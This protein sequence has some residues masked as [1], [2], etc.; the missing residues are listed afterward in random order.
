MNRRIAINISSNGTPCAPTIV[1]RPQPCNAEQSAHGVA[2]AQAGVRGGGPRVSPGEE[3]EPGAA[4][5]RG[6]PDAQFYFTGRTRAAQPLV[7]YGRSARPSSRYFCLSAHRARRAQTE[8]GYWP[9][10]ARVL[11]VRGQ[12]G[13]VGELTAGPSAE[14]SARGPK[15]PCPSSHLAVPCLVS[16]AAF[17]HP[18]ARKASYWS[19]TVA[20]SS[21]TGEN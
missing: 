15:A 1:G 17:I 20:R 18:W 12:R 9:A 14:R 8:V 19:E 16:E 10:D 6:W 2:A 11:I 4:W 5:V 13:T 3:T 21:R 7:G